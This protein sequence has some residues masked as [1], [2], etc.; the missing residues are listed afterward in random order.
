MSCKIC[1]DDGPNLIAPC[2]CKGTMQFVHMPCLALW[3]AA[4]RSD[5]CDICH[6]SLSQVVED[7]VV[8][9]LI[10]QRIVQLQAREKIP[11]TLQCA[12]FTM[13][14]YTIVVLMLPFIARHWGVPPI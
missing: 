11:F 6:A 4:K 8:N 14:L 1:W 10:A 3:L 9:N 13:W 5:T 2:Q 7:V 12:L